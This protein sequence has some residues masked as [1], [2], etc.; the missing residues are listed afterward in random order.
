MEAFGKTL[1]QLRTERRISQQKLAES[2]HLQRTT[3]TNYEAG[4][5]FP[6]LEVFVSIVK[7]FG[8]PSDVL[9]GFVDNTLEAVPQSKPQS[10]ASE[11]IQSLPQHPFA[12]ATSALMQELGRATRITQLEARRAVLLEMADDLAVEIQTLRSEDPDAPKQVKH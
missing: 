6:T 8:V 11:S 12:V 5:S 1:K 10:N 4:N 7:Y 3:V 2:L 9:L